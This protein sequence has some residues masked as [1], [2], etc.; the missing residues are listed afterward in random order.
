M[1]SA[2]RAERDMYEPVCVWLNHFLTERFKNARIQ[3]F[4]ASTTR[5]S[6]L[7]ENHRLHEGLAPDWPT[8]EI[9]ID[10]VGFVHTST[11]THIAFVECKNVPLTLDHLAQLLGYARIARPQFAFLISPQG[12]NIS[13]VQ[14][15]QTHR[16]LDVLEYSH[17]PNKSPRS[18]V[19]ARWNTAANTI[20]YE[21][22]ITTDSQKVELGRW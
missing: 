2:Y 4:D 12:A 13:L 14:L 16:R 10:V 18:I 8:W 3:V 11:A 21:Q 1:I 9:Q 22:L 17:Y 20:A 19:V 7:I 6:A 15:L 5:L